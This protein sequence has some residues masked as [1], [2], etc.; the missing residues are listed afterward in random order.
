MSVFVALMAITA[1][2]S[3]P[4]PAP[5]PAITFQLFVAVAAGMFLGSVAGGI[6]MFVYLALGLMGFP[7]FTKGGGFAYV[8]QPT[9]GFILGFVASAFITGSIWADAWPRRIL[10]VIVSMLACYAIGIPY[11]WLLLN[12]AK[13]MAFLTAVTMMLPYLAKDIILG[14][15]LFGFAQTMSKVAPEL[16]QRSKK[17]LT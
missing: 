14:G 16:M 5:L 12:S 3:V 10:A 4:L 11:F 17:S 15:V 8:L 9:F 7:I 2:I 13:P 6:A 1:R